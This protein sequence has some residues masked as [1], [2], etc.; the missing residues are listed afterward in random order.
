MKMVYLQEESF[1]PDAILSP[2]YIN[3]N[4]CLASNTG[5]KKPHPFGGGG[6]L[7]WWEGGRDADSAHFP[8]SAEIRNSPTF[9]G[10]KL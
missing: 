6:G 8:D 2:L 7:G 5:R 4:N 1:A 10:K 9:G 3:L